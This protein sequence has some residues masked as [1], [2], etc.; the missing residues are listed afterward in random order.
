MLVAA[1]DSNLSTFVDLAR[2]A[3]L[4]ETLNGAGPYTV[5]APTDDAFAALPAGTLEALLADG[6]RLSSVLGHHVAEGR[7]TAD[8]LAGMPTIE[9]LQGEPVTVTVQAD[10][11]MEIDGTTVNRTDIQTGNGVIHVI[12]A[13]ILPP[14]AIPTQTSVAPST[15]TAPAVD[16]ATATTVAPPATQT[17]TAAVHTTNGT[18]VAE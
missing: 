9:M 13:V 1:A 8:G 11:R 4:A 5:F 3:G 6:D 10:G 15:T 2:K 12:D 17:E 7:H 16:T 14:D 18:P